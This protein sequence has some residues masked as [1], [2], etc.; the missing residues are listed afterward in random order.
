MGP[1]PRP[2][3]R[4]SGNRFAGRLPVVVAALAFSACAPIGTRVATDPLPNAPP[5][6]TRPWDGSGPA[7]PPGGV[8]ATRRAAAEFPGVVAGP[9]PDVAY[10]VPGLIDLA[11]RINP[12][13]RLSWERARSA[14]ARLGVAGGAYLPMLTLL[15]AAGY[16]QQENLAGT[17]PVFTTGAQVTPGLELSWVLIDFGR[18][19][20]DYDR[21]LQQLLGANLQF[22]RV[23]QQVA[24]DVQRA[25]YAYDAAQA[26][27][28]AAEATLTAAAAVEAEAVARLDRGLATSTEMLL[29]RQE[30]ARAAY[31][32]Q[33]AERLAADAQATLAEVLGISPTAP[34]QVR[35]LSELP[36]PPRLA[37]SVEAVIDRALMQ[38]PDLAASLA[39]LRARAAEVR[40]AQAQFMPR[41]ELAG[42]VGGMAGEYSP[43]DIPAHFRYAEPVY[44]GLVRFSWGLFEGFVR[45]NR[46][47]EAEAE[48]GAAAASLSELQLRVLRDVWK[49]YADV[50]AAFLQ[51][52]FAEAF[53]RASQDAYDAALIGYRNGLA[54]IVDLLDAERG[55]ARARTTMV[56]SRAEVLMTAA[57]LAFAAGDPGGR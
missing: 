33:A 42:G 21:A 19:A 35:E 32:V 29:A 43:Q 22:N 44:A 3:R 13:T 27:V 55:L 40:R 45:R 9:D 18:R 1:A 53:L 15:A 14:A 16:V 28:D 4:P 8:D 46:V 12:Q 34:L 48:R 31:E 17:G 2:D 39:D 49:A 10:D 20:A 6:P 38:R 26:Q 50:Q 56:T 7:Y 47:L 57:A 24:Y 30:K 41:I 51:Y 36:L 52:E 11:L 23:H 25:L 5:G 37:D 54:T